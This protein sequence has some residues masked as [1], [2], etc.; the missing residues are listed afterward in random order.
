VTPSSPFSYGSLLVSFQFAGFILVPAVCIQLLP[1]SSQFT[2]FIWFL[3]NSTLVRHLRTVHLWFYPSSPVSSRFLLL[4]CSSLS[5]SPRFLPFAYGPSF[6]PN[7]SSHFHILVH[8]TTHIF[9]HDIKTRPHPHPR[10][11]SQLPFLEQIHHAYPARRRLLG[12]CR[13]F[14]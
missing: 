13:R 8:F 9:P 5:V 4:A 12:F 2:V 10:W 6:S 3:A 14:R 11:R 1:V 7:A